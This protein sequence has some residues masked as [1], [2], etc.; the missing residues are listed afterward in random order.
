MTVRTL[1]MDLS[2]K[3][4]QELFDATV[5]LASCTPKLLFRVDKINKN[6]LTSCWPQIS[7]HFA[8]LDGIL[9]KTGGY[10]IHQKKIHLQLRRFLE[11]HAMDWALADSERAIY[12]LRAQL[13]TLASLK[14]EG[15]KPPRNHGALQVLVD[16]VTSS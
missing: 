3:D 4:A 8:L 9:T 7:K 12:N 16:K 15:K 10:G 6:G 2:D 1:S 5:P 14:R 11:S 13:R